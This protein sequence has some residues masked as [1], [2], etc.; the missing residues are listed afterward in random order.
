MA[1]VNPSMK[2][3]ATNSS[4]I[5]S[6]PIK[7][8]QLIFVQDTRQIFLDVHRQRQLYAQIM[9][10]LNDEVRKA[11][12]SP[13]EGFYYTKQESVFWSYFNNEWHQLTGEDPMVVFADEGLPEEGVDNTIYVKDRDFY[14]WNDDLQDYLTVGGT[15]L[16][17]EDMGDQS[18]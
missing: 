15:E 11:L 7:D 9:I 10:L 3:I 2:F 1:T 12:I 13:I 16:D 18:I 5:N 6:I 4:K 17:W 8:G 14:R